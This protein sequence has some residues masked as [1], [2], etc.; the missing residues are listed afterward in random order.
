MPKGIMDE[1]FVWVAV[2]EG[3]EYTITAVMH[4]RIMPLVAKKIGMINGC[5]K[6]AVQHGKNMGQTVRLKHFS[7]VETLK[8]ID[9]E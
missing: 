4:D 7:G 2:D 6:L 9:C 1:Y 5:E 3:V 8:E